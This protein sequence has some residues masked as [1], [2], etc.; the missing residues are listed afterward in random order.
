MPA[1]DSGIILYT[2]RSELCAKALGT[3][4]RQEI[5]PLA[6]KE[7]LS[8]LLK[9]AEVDEE[10]VPQTTREASEEIARILGGLPLAIERSAACIFEHRW[11][12]AAYLERL[13]SAKISTLSLATGQETMQ[14]NLV[15][16]LRLP[17]RQLSAHAIA[18]MKVMAHLDYHS[19]PIALLT[20]G[21]QSS[22]RKPT[23]SSQIPV[24]KRRWRR[25]LESVNR[26]FYYSRQ[27]SPSDQKQPEA[28]NTYELLE[29]LFFDANKLEAAISSII[30]A[31]M[32]SRKENGR[33]WMHDLVCELCLADTTPSERP[34]VAEYAVTL[35]FYAFPPAPENY[36]AWDVCEEMAT[37]ARVSLQHGS[38]DAASQASASNLQF[39]LGLYYQSRGRF[40]DALTHYKDAVSAFQQTLGA[41]HTQTLIA[42]NS[43][44]NLLDDQGKYEES[45]AWHKITLAARSEA[46]GPKH[47]DTLSSLNNMGA[48]FRKLADFEHAILYYFQALEGFNHVLGEE[49]PDTLST[50]GN[51]A[52]VYHEQGRYQDA[53]NW[54]D[55]ALKGRIKKLGARH[56]QTLSTMNNLGVTISR[57]GRFKSAMRWYMEAFK[58]F[59]QQLGSDHPHTLSTCNNMALTLQGS[60]NLREALRWHCKASEGRQSVLG[61]S[62]P[63]TFSSLANIATAYEELG[64]REASQKHHE[65][66]KSARDKLLGQRHPDT[67]CSAINTLMCQVKRGEQPISKSLKQL[68]DILEGFKSIL[69]SGHPLTLTVVYNEGVLREIQGDFTGSHECY[70]QAFIGQQRVLGLHGETILSARRI[71]SVMARKTGREEASRWYDGAIQRIPTQIQGDLPGDSDKPDAEMEQA[72]DGVF[73]VDEDALASPF[74]KDEDP[75]TPLPLFLVTYRLLTW[76]SNRL[77]ENPYSEDKGGEERVPQTK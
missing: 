6:V 25:M 11:T 7:S 36:Q 5:L 15:E 13:K 61:T 1:G 52:N 23:V 40:E 47:P 27:N 8:L 69:G 30:A 55:K 65:M 67:L 12:F 39:L 59:E 64:D 14:R 41:A 68:Q 3:S 58:A 31:S 46:L 70:T 73:A 18:L 49:H 29:T 17:M 44:A 77:Q 43:I 50:I 75:D 26:N 37:H 53:L 76:C 48:T 66:A 19:V 74:D 38:R 60:G 71:A 20:L 28:Q 54:H 62:N 4:G 42:T 57:L 21:S 9:A 56:P 35:C 33:L 51:I 2:M 10:A 24:A 32:M 63:D 34:I 72:P 45:L 22:I 16:S